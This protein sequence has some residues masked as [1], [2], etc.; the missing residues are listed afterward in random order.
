MMS[1]PT[2]GTPVTFAAGSRLEQHKAFFAGM[3]TGGAPPKISPLEG[4]W[5]VVKQWDACDERLIRPGK[6]RVHPRL[7]A[8][9]PN[10]RELATAADAWRIVRWCSDGSRIGDVD[11]ASYGEPER[12]YWSPD[13]E[14]VLLEARTAVAEYWSVQNRDGLMVR[15]VQNDAAF[16][17][18]ESYGVDVDRMRNFSPWR[19]G[20]HQILMV[21]SGA[22]LDLVSV[23]DL[24][25]PLPREIRDIFLIPF[26]GLILAFLFN[27]LRL[28]FTTI[29]RIRPKTLAGVAPAV[30]ITF[31]TLGA[32]DQ[33][34]GP[35][36]WHPSGQYVAVTTGPTYDDGSVRRVH[37]VSFDTAEIVTSIS[38]AATAVR[39]SPGGRLLVCATHDGELIAWDSHIWTLR[40]LSDEE[41]RHTWAQNLAPLVGAK[42]AL[43]ADGTLYAENAPGGLM[44]R[45][46]G[47]EDGA[48]VSGAGRVAS[49][50]WSPTDPTCFASVGGDEPCSARV[51]KLTPDL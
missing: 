44:I 48:I 4:T 5:K 34:I 14:L 38:P 31:G 32:L 17:P 45:K 26:I 36:A 33:W 6:R 47:D 20:A 15:S 12:L 22:R 16:L 2:T 10:G 13:G 30:S 29:F 3:A 51:W 1:L 24:P 50:A 23:E 40:A 37:I 39:W 49:V 11:R 46:I 19:P 28:A 35:Y 43:N 41:R 25:A 42:G 7:I 18:R 9:S 27:L 8:W 21:R